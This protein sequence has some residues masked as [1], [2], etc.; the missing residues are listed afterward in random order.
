MLPNWSSPDASIYALIPSARFVAS[1][2]RLFIDALGVA[3]REAGPE[4]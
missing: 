3:L 1:K 4:P 2:T